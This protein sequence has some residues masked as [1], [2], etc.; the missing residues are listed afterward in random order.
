MAGAG[1]IGLLARLIAAAPQK[2]LVRPDEVRMSGGWQD[3]LS[4]RCMEHP[5]TCSR[6]ADLLA[7][8]KTYWN[9]DDRQLLQARVDQEKQLRCSHNI[10]ETCMPDSKFLVTSV[11]VQIN[12]PASLVWDV[13][14]DLDN[15]PQWNPYTVK[16]ASRT[17]SATANLK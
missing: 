8:M 10:K 6:G 13:L 4:D 12:A 16:V 11:K 2:F 3:G 7:D 17:Q 9:G 14:V 15:Y 1:E 5:D